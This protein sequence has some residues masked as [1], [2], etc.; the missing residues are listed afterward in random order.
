VEVALARAE[1]RVGVIPKEAAVKIE[2]AAKLENIDFVEMKAEFDRV[3][4]PILPFVHQLAK[5]CDPEA[6]R[7]VHYGS[8]T[9]DILDTGMV[10]Q[11]RN[12]LKLI[13]EDMNGIIDALADL[14]YTHRDTV[15]S[16]RTFQQLAAPITFGYKVAVWLDEMLRHRDR[17]Y[18]M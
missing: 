2:E 11:I 7:W 18:E 17:F 10:L 14:A 6:A 16:G 1:A 3:G 5:A 9:Q 15:M 4:F 13:E 12:G 8:T